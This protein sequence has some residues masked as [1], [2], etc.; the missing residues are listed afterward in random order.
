MSR[1]GPTARQIQNMLL[2]K[3]VGLDI[4]PEI[5]RNF[6]MKTAMR[7]TFMKRINSEGFILTLLQVLIAGSLI[8]LIALLNGTIF[9]NYLGIANESLLRH[10]SCILL[11]E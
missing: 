6:G 9:Y 10:S 7:I 2:N 8:V 5:N 3:Q 1:V 11:K 4:A